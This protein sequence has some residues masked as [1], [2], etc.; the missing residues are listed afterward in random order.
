[1]CEFF[2]SRCEF[3]FHHWLSV[4]FPFSSSMQY[5]CCHCVWSTAFNSVQFSVGKKVVSS[6]ELSIHTK[7]YGTE[8]MISLWF[9][10][11]FFFRSDC[12]KT[13]CSIK[14][15]RAA[16]NPIW[17]TYSYQMNKKTK[18]NIYHILFHFIRVSSNNWTVLHFDGTKQPSAHY[19]LVWMHIWDC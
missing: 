17:T 9:S 7:L 12:N 2:H 19:S 4:N 10:S 15:K 3:L 8:L 13:N 16:Y 1:M 6:I 5:V 14:K 11:D 18:L